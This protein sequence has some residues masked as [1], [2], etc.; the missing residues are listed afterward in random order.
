M[1]F[2]CLPAVSLFFW[3]S[4][5]AWFNGRIHLCHNDFDVGSISSVF[6]RVLSDK[7]GLNSQALMKDVFPRLTV[8]VELLIGTSDC[9]LTL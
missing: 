5:S 6:R 3:L 7:D 4:S 9:I 2:S 8:L 1:T